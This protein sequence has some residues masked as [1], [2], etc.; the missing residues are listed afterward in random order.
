VG[1]ELIPPSQRSI[2]RVDVLATKG[3]SSINGVPASTQFFFEQRKLSSVR[4]VIDAS[5]GYSDLGNMQTQKIAW[6]R[7]DGDQSAVKKICNAAFISAVERRADNIF[8][9]TSNLEAKRVAHSDY[10]PRSYECDR[11]KCDSESYSDSWAAG[12]KHAEANSIELE[13]VIRTNKY[14]YRKEDYYSVGTREEVSCIT[15]FRFSNK[16]LGGI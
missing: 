1:H 16:K 12:Y 9:K 4:L 14:S 6:S 5:Y 7:V 3:L 13:H 15:Q 10:F 8:S 2:S 11:Y